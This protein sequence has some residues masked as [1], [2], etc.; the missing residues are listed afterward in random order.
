MEK[1]ANIDGA[2][3]RDGVV[4]GLILA[5]LVATPAIVPLL[6]AVPVRDPDVWWHLATGRWIHENGAVPF[7]DPFASGVADA[8]WAAYSWTYELFV[9]GA[10]ALFGLEGLFAY[11]VLISLAIAAALYH[12]V[13]GLEPR[14]VPA[15]VLT[16]LALVATWAHQGARSFLLS[17]FMFTVVLDVLWSVRR[18]CDPRRLL[19]LV[20]LFAL[21]GN[22][23]IQFVYGLALLGIA[24]TEAVFDAATAE[25]HGGSRN[26]F[27]PGW[28]LGVTAAA[29]L[30][31]LATPYTWR[32]YAMLPDLAGQP[33]MWTYVSE[34]Q[35]PTFRSLPEWAFLGLAL[36]A[37]FAL[38]KREELRPFPVL[39]L[40]MGVLLAFRATRDTWVLSIAAVSVI[41]H[42]TGLSDWRLDRDPVRPSPATVLL[43]TVLLLF[44]AFKYRSATGRDLER[45]VA[46]VFPVEAAAFVADALD[47]VGPGVLCRL[48]N[49][50]DW[51]GY[52]LWSVPG[53]AVSMDGR[54]L[55][56]GEDS[57]GR[58]MR[59][60][61]GADG[62][63]TDPVLLDSD[64]IVARRTDRLTRM[65]HADPRFS[66]VHDDDV[67]TVF[68]PSPQLTAGASRRSDSN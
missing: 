18:G 38:G 10:H 3:P 8:P 62:W 19:V 16:T 21:W 49:H 34:L 22:L 53:C 48:Y 12:L 4:R 61:S 39:L 59:V 57:L 5:L 28:T 24:S 63:D 1:G 67:A 35:A 55:T 37:P 20:P 17:A 66:V 65:L 41:A 64:L 56:F 46:D 26:G 60:W 45:V 47:E 33:A 58:S 15:V 50:M 25:R 31:T 44:G 43:T 54:I 7:V 30:A 27:P 6:A 13:R 42:V 52:L 9:Y 14:F 36:A 40:A 2:S 32:L 68:A 29:V 51:G 23:H 11:S